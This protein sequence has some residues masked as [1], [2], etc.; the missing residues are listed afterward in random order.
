MDPLHQEDEDEDENVG[1][2]DEKDRREVGAFI[3]H[4]DF[5]DL[6]ELTDEVR[7]SLKDLS[8]TEEMFAMDHDFTC[9]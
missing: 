2:K 6:N 8:Q 1:L 9:I 4:E 5:N 7:A 3:K